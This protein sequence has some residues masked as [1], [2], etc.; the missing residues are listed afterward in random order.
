MEF[1]QTAED[2]P[3]RLG[4][5]PGSFNPV[6]IAHLALARAAL[7]VV[8]EV[9]FVLPRAFPHKLYVGATFEQRITMLKAAIAGE[10]A[11]SIAASDGGLFAEIAE[12]CRTAYGNTRLTFLCGRDAAE[13]IV[14]WDYGTPDALSGMLRRFDLLVAARRGAYEVPE[15]WRTSIERLE[16]PDAFDHVSS[17]EV[18]ERIAHGDSWEHLVPPQICRQI[19]EIY[20]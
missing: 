4:I 20:G 17:T 14:H 10:P 2:I 8:N 18:R 5:L 19:R 11:F 9:V 12:E 16:L 3:S 13:R 7:A 1:F 15:E 6:T